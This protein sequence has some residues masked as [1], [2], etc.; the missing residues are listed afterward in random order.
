MAHYK[1]VQ[2]AVPLR[3]RPDEKKLRKLAEKWAPW[4][5]VAARLFWAYYRAAKQREGISE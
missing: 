5:G 3:T 2:K 4:R 1:A